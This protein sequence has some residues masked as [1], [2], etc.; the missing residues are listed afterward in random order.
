MAADR[1][2]EQRRHRR[3]SASFLTEVFNRDRLCGRF[4]SRNVSAGGMFLETGTAYLTHSDPIEIN[5]VL[6]GEKYP[7]RGRVVRH[8]EGGVGIKVSDVDPKF[9]KALTSMIG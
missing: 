2:G 3:L 4:V 9:Y 8:A 7:M 6:F 5:V 1:R